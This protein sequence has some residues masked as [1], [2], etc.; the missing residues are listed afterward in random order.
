MA[1]SALGW[2]FAFHIS[3]PKRLHCLRCIF[4]AHVIHRCAACPL[5]RSKLRDAI[6]QAGAYAPSSVDLLRRMAAAVNGNAHGV[7]ATSGSNTDQGF[8]MFPVSRRALH[9]ILVFF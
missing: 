5:P 9:Y 3:T 4:R 2:V 7:G 8:G 1:H 6:C